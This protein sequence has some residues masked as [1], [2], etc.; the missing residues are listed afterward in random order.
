[1]DLSNPI[2]SVIPIG[3]GEVLAVLARTEQPLTGRR[4]ADLTNGRLSQKGTNLALRALVRTGLVLV[5][6]HPPA[7]LYRLNRQHLAARSIEELVTLRGR[8]IDAMRGHLRDWMIPAWGA[9]LFGSAARGDGDEGS[10]IDVL[11]VRPDAADDAE[12]AWDDQVDHFAAA[13]LAWT[14]N[15]CAVIEY[16]PDELAALLAREDRLAVDLRAD[17]V[18]LTSRQLPRPAAAARRRR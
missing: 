2:R 12:A 5:E 1:V 10:D 17:G 3:Q 7:N 16:G 13:V 18:A 9:W 11:V 14:G 8:L 15:R 4:V 6:A